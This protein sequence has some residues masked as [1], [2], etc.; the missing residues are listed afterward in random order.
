MIT[1]EN[2]EHINLSIYNF[3][4]KRSSYFIVI[5]KEFVGEVY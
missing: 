2:V 4:N 3:F 1:S 5:V